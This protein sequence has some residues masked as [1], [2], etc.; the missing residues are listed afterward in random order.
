MPYPLQFALIGH[1][2]LVGIKAA[3]PRKAALLPL[4]GSDF[5]Q[6]AILLIAGVVASELLV[7]FFG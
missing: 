7:V 1:L 5:A 3:F 2:S 6:L 4:G